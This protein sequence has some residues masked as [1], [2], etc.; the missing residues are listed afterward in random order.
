MFIKAEDV[1]LGSGCFVTN[2]LHQDV[3]LSAL[4]KTTTMDTLLACPCQAS[5]SCSIHGHNQLILHIVWITYIHK[6]SYVVF[7]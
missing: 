1:L 4:K 7:F 5:L 2:V 6:A 3:K